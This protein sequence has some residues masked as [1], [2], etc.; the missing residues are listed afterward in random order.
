MKFRGV[1]LSVFILLIVGPT[2]RAEQRTV[3][4][5]ANVTLAAMKEMAP[6]FLDKDSDS[7][8]VLNFQSPAP[9]DGFR[10]VNQGN[11]ALSFSYWDGE[12]AWVSVKIG[13]GRP[14]SVS[15]PK[16][17]SSITVALHD[18]KENKNYMLSSG[19]T[20]QISW[21]NQTQTWVLAGPVPK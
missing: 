8:D 3:L 4:S 6:P 7:N 2:A 20:Y 18:G 5:S 10:I 21:S 15:C 14:Q 12:S 1:V 17:G 16:C 19:S 11:Q 13:S 9:A